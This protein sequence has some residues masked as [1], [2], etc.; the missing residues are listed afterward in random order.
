MFFKNQ[1]KLL[2]APVGNGL[3]NN[4]EDIKTAKSYFAQDGRYKKPVENGYIDKELD[5]AIYNFQRDY[6]LKVDGRM[7]PGGETEATLVSS[8]MGMQRPPAKKDKPPAYM[9]P[10][11][12][13]AAPAIPAVLG[14]LAAMTG[15]TITKM[16]E[17]WKNMS[18]EEREDI[19]NDLPS[20]RPNAEPPDENEKRHCEELYED[21]CEQCEQL[22][23][24]QGDYLGNVC[25]KSAFERY[26]SCRADKPE[27]HWAPLQ[28]WR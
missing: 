4:E 2:S 1:I 7:N 12:A 8:T 28:D 5:D 6:D 20:V 21:E 22:R 3:D 15:V 26:S 27:K 16:Q 18:K 19:L 13:A 10:A 25:K 14:A 24:Q 17:T 9:M 23:K 11:A